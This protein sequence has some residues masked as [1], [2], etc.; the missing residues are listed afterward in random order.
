VDTGTG[1]FPYAIPDGKRAVSLEVREVTAVG[2]LLTAGNRVDVIG[3]FK[4]KGAP[5]LADNEYILS[6]RTILQNVEVMSVAQE[7]T[8]PLPVGA[9]GGDT[10]DSANNGQPPEDV[11]EQPG[12]A[13]VTLALSPQE[14]Q[15]LI[16][17]QVIAD[18]VWTSL[19]PAGESAPVDVPSHDI[20]VR[21]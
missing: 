4:I 19:R 7:H 6:V 2:G 13:T 8:E 18:S 5:G 21:E 17:A 15:E 14:A 10:A 3:A 20:I 11:K 12:A 1:S 9:T 16:S